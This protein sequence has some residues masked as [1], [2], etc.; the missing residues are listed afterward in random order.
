M[1][2]ACNR[3]QEEIYRCYGACGSQVNPTA[4]VLSEIRG[5]DVDPSRVSQVVRMI[6]KK[7]KEHFG[8]LEWDPTDN[9]IQQ[10]PVKVLLNDIETGPNTAYFW[11]AKTQYIPHNMTIEYGKVIS[12]SAKWLG[13][14]EIIYHEDRTN[15]DKKL[16]KKLIALYD[17]ASVVVGHNGR[18]FDTKT[19]L[20]RASV[21]GLPP[22]SPFKQVDTYRDIKRFAKFPRYSLEFLLEHYGIGQK[23]KH[24][25][26]AGFELWEECMKGNEEAW[27]ELKI[28]NCQDTTD[29]EKLY[30]KVRPYLSNHPNLGILMEENRPICPKCASG[31]L[32]KKGFGTTNVGKYQRYQCKN[33]KGFLRGRYTQLDKEKRKVLTVNEVM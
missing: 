29:L 26:F 30:L 25:K 20:G 8:E 15:N 10:R 16:V 4:R 24:R 11:D 21:H 33:C 14:D 12:F 22:P 27:E 3:D 19:M 9:L 2:Y 13:V 18:A 6:Q 28:Y 17:E 5:I 23:Y 1:P 7:A 32:W 31:E